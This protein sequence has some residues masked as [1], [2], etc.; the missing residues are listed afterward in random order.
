MRLHLG[1]EIKWPILKATGDKK[2]SA[3]FRNRAKTISFPVKYQRQEKGITLPTGSYVKAKLMTGVD[4]PESKT[5]PVLLALD[6]SYVGPNQHRIDLS[7]CFIIAKS[8]PSLATERMNFQATRLSCV[9]KRG[10]FFERKISGFVA[11]DIDNSFAVKAKLKSKQGRVAKMA[12]LKSVVDGVGEIIT[13]KAQN[14]GGANPDSANVL[15]QSGATK[16]RI[17]SKRL[18]FKAGRIINADPRGG[19]GARCLDHYAREGFT[20]Q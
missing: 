13:R 12:F 6:Y 15:V 17:K 4:A 14:I 7:G 5:Y 10:Q 1:D 16:C 11:D 19:V 9:S 18:V 8:S 3:P 20:A 2:F